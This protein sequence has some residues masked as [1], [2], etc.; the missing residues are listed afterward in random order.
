MDM[1]FDKT[2]DSELGDSKTPQNLARHDDLLDTT[3]C[4]ES[5]GVFKGWKNFLFIILFAGLLL[6]QV[7]F[8]SVNSGWISPGDQ[9][10]A[11]FEEVLPVVVEEAN[12]PPA[13]PNLADMVLGHLPEDPNKILDAAAKIAADPNLLPDEDDQESQ[14]LATVD[15]KYAKWIIRAL[16]FVLIF[17]GMLYCLTLL[18][19][20]KVSLL[21][22]LGGINHICRA[23]FLSLVFVVRRWSLWYCFCPGSSCSD[24]Y[25][26]VSG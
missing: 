6:Q 25:P 13:D 20:L 23:F 24:R 12:Q 18:F 5:I 22:R 14:F 11:P 16:N 7:L 19:A 1:D 8:W 3:D 2:L 15:F 9:V 26:V 4:L 21:G 10:E 17:A